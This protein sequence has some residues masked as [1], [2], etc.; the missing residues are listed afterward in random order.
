[1]T[2]ALA[3]DGKQM[4]AAA[5]MAAERVNSDGGIS[6]MGGANLRIA[7]ADTTGEAEVG[8][9]EAQRLIDSEGAVALVGTYQSAVSSNVARVAERAQVPFVIDVATADEILDQGYQYTFRIQPNATTMGSYGARYLVEIA[10]AGG[11]PVATV[12]YVH[13]QSEFGTSVFEA[14]REEAESQGLQVVEEISYDA[15]NVSDLTPELTRVKSANPDVLAATGYYSDGL[16]LSEAASAVRPEISAVYGVANGAFDLPQFPED[17]G[18]AG[19]YY[20]S[21]NYHYDA[22]KERVTEVRERFR[23]ETG[24]VM[25]TPA[26]FSYQAVLLIADAL[27]RAGSGEPQEL[28][29]AISETS[30]EDHLLAYR[31]PIE[32]DE[33]GENV[34]AMPIVMQVQDGEVVQVYPEEFAQE[35][36][37]FPATP[38]N[39]GGE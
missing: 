13:E 32:F 31:G 17:A 6:S 23:E 38:W 4:D 20:L 9:R 14:F 10:D 21:S 22:T 8:Q 1:V 5:K 16:L 29:T 2:G 35:E 7:S 24:E 36:P 39:T 33:T 19:N 11:S 37:V 25:R 28:R 26:V 27:E 30:L 15:F 34:N 18:E 3:L 12:A